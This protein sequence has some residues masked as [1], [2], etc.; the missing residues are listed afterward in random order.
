MIQT[1][2]PEYSHISNAQHT[3]QLYSMPLLQDFNEPLPVSMVTCR[4]GNRNGWNYFLEPCLESLDF[5][6]KI[7][8]RNDASLILS[9]VILIL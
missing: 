8:L 1:V 3:T 6:I 5:I 9:P 4:Y 2:D 7:A